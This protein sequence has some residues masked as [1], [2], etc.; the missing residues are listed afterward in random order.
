MTDCRMSWPGRIC[1]W[2]AVGWLL[3]GPSA[4]ADGVYDQERIEEQGAAGVLRVVG[5]Y[6]SGDAGAPFRS[7]NTAHAVAVLPDGQALVFGDALVDPAG[8]PAREVLAERLGRIGHGL[9]MEPVAWD[10]RAR[11]WTRPGMPPECLYRRTHHTM[12][13]LPNHKVLVA[14]GWCDQPRM[15]DD[16]TPLAMFTGLSLWSG[17][18]GKWEPVSAALSAERILHTASLLRDGG[19]MFAGGA[20]GLHPDKP[21]LNVVGDVEL[22]RDGKVASL[23]PLRVAR[24]RHTATALA[25]GS[26]MVAGGSDGNGAALDAVEIWNPASQAWHGAVPLASRRHSHTATILDDGRVLIAGGVGD[27]GQPL[28]SVE[29]W[30]P[31]TRTWSVGEALPYP[32]RGH[33]AVRLASGDVLVAGGHW[34]RA[35]PPG[36]LLLWSRA[37]EHWRPAGAFVPSMEDKRQPL[38]TLAPRPDGSAHVFMRH[39]VLHWRPQAAKDDPSPPYGERDH[40]ATAVLADGRVMIS[41]GRLTNLYNHLERPPVADVVEIFDPASGRF[42]ATGRMHQPRMMHTLLSLPDGRVLAA[43][44]WVWHRDGGEVPLANHPE[45]WNP[46]T[47]SW[48]VVDEIE[49]APHEWVHAGK[50]ADGRIL[51][52]ASNETTVATPAGQPPYR[53]WLWDPRSGKAEA[54]TV[55]LG[56]RSA[57]A[58]AILPDGRVLRVGGNSRSFLGGQPSRWL[59]RPDPGAELWDSRSGEITRLDPP[60]GWDAAEGKALVTRNGDAVFVAHQPVRFGHQTKLPKAAVLSWNA[61]SGWL[62]L[63]SLPSDENWPMRELPD[64]TLWTPWH[65]LPPG[66]SAWLAAPPL[67]QEAPA[68]VQLPS[69]GL[70][71]L[72]MHAPHAA[73]GGEGERWLPVL[74]QQAAPVWLGKPAI[75]ELADSRVLV[76]G[77]VEARQNAMPSAFVWNPKHDGW[78]RAAPPL[79]P[80]GKAAQVIRLRSGNVLYLSIGRD[81]ELQCELWKPGEDRWDLCDSDIMTSAFATPPGIGLLDDG[82]VLLVA[83]TVTAY[84]FDEA[85]RQWTVMTGE[86][87]D[88][89][90]RDGI[91]VRPEKPLQRFL[92]DRSGSWLDAGGAAGRYW[93]R[94]GTRLSPGYNSRSAR[95]REPEYGAPRMLWDGKKRQW[96]YV[97]RSSGM[98][99]EAG[100]LADGCAFS[101][102]PPTL[103]DPATGEAARLP[104]PGIGVTGSDGDMAVLAD[105]TVVI[106]GKADEGIGNGFFRR[107][108]TC[109]GF[110]LAAGDDALMPRRLASE[111]KAGASTPSSGASATWQTVLAERWQSH[112]WLLLAALGPLFLYFLLRKAILPPVKRGLSALIPARIVG[113]LKRQL[114]K[115]YARDTR[116]VVYGLL[117]LLLAPTLVSVVSLKLGQAGRAC[118]ESARACLDPETGILRSVPKLERRLLF[119]PRAKPEIPCRFVGTWNARYGSKVLLATLKDDGTY[120]MTDP[121]GARRG[122]AGYT[123]YWMAQDGHLVWRHNSGHM[124][125]LDIN[126][127]VSES[128]QHFELVERDGTRS[129]FELVKA[130]ESATCKQ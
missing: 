83:D 5:S 14:G 69:Q 126:P 97:L 129:A 40:F 94:A 3:A 47:G 56:P 122:A 59:D 25:D 118:E 49:F 64:G 9:N 46:A 27:K 67:I 78:G 51:L 109:A 84:A 7:D 29:I 60:P 39:K 24:A 117:F 11:G 52:V 50:L 86:W 17:E 102:Q 8:R 106:M 127:I 6:P 120:V 113:T 89:T 20:T 82:R 16:A 130:G 85:D 32:L 103:F 76:V 119:F 90:L 21:G 80:L 26:I 79:H 116:I 13:V 19:V 101:W 77:K 2:C 73:I 111:A 53:A 107:K 22:F 38:L 72:S 43:G 44:G 125:E 74:P 92:D 34:T 35:A 88:L 15:A 18:T 105:G 48:A 115:S 30:N 4:H 58:I 61:R 110:E 23:P 63:P 45:V 54:K 70:L 33:A 71:A 93:E 81:D 12:T 104:D 123:G 62:L 91:A 108:V 42:T 1:A 36:R 37:G 75:V 87:N 98:G 121:T 95:I 66:A 112:R 128:A 124:P 114:P 96:T 99:R 41:G 55:A 28:A 31:Q 10:P 57:A 100:L 68:F 65:S